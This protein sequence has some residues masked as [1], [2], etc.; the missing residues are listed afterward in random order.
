MIGH[1]YNNYLIC[2]VMLNNV[3]ISI[4]AKKKY[5]TP[6]VEN[7]PCQPASI[8]CISMGGD[9]DYSTGG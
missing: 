5:Q 3:N 8:I 4:M 1:Q 6:Q 9:I 2:A 7:T